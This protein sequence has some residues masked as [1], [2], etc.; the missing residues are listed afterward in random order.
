MLMRGAP[1]YLRKEAIADI[2]R[3]DDKTMAFLDAMER[4]YRDFLIIPSEQ[5]RLYKKSQ[6]YKNVS[7]IEETR[8]Q[9]LKGVSKSYALKDLMIKIGG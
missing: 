1:F 2:S 6:I 5:G 7:L 8:R 9:L 4:V 3:D